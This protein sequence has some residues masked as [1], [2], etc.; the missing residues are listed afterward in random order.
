MCPEGGEFPFCQ[1]LCYSKYGDYTRP[2]LV[3]S[4][5]LPPLGAMRR[6]FGAFMTSECPSEPSDS[7]SCSNCGGHYAG[8][9]GGYAQAVLGL[10]GRGE[11]EELARSFSVEGVTSSRHMTYFT[12]LS[13]QVCA[14]ARLCHVPPSLTRYTHP[15][16]NSSWQRPS[17]VECCACFPFVRVHLD[18]ANLRRKRRR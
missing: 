7:S 17:L 11:P 15:T 4:P 16:A 6:Y 12:P 3:P 9:L 5:G 18:T 13:T 10:R 14:G 1:K 8:D 2:C